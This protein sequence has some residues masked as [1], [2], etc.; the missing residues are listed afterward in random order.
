MGIVLYN[1]IKVFFL[2]EPMSLFLSL[3]QP[4]SPKGTRSVLRIP[5]MEKQIGRQTFTKTLAVH[6]LHMSL[7]IHYITSTN[8]IVLGFVFGLI[9]LVI[10]FFT[11]MNVSNTDD[12]DEDEKESS[13]AVS[14]TKKRVISRKEVAEHNNSKDLWVVIDNKVYNLTKFVPDHPGGEEAIS[15]HAGGD[16]TKGFF[17][18]QHP[19]RAFFEVEDYLIGT[20]P[21]NERMRYLSTEEIAK[22]NKPEDLWLIVDQRVFDVTS[23]V[24][25]HPG[26][27]EKLLE[28][29]GGKDATKMFYGTQHKKHVYP[30]INE[31]FIGYVFNE[32]D[33]DFVKTNRKKKANDAKVKL[34]KDYYTMEEVSKHNNS[35]D[36]WI[37]IHDSIYNITTFQHEHPGGSIIMEN[38]GA[39]ST[40]DFENAKHPDYVKDLMVDL[41]VGYLKK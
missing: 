33:V 36:A 21:E 31:Y 22:H 20:V 19:E 28:N 16:A 6:Q 40:K 12:D 32:G 23:F 35:E 25:F 17:G 27:I 37:V 18:Y 24:N 30:M 15:Q 34:T 3:S 29:S 5:V 26:G 14:T 38:V 1:V 9:G 7:I 11:N 2:V 8:P 41:F 4:S 13:S 10:Y 39:D